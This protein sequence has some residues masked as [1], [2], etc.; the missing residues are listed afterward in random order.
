MGACIWFSSVFCCRLHL[1]VVA[2][3]A[4]NGFHIDSPLFYMMGYTPCCTAAFFLNIENTT[5]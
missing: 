2:V 3:A 1:A 5:L 4:V